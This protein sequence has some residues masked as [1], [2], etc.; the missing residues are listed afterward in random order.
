MA[1]HVE[2]ERKF[3]LAEGQELP[4]LAGVAGLGPAAEFDLV[5]TY[6]DSPDFRLAGARQVIRRRT[7]GTDDGWHLKQPGAGPDQR[8]E[9][10]APVEYRRPPQQFRELVAGNLNGAPLVPVAVLRTHR[11]ERQ[12]IGPDGTVLALV[13]TDLVDASAGGHRQRWREAEVE[14]VHGDA[15]FLDLVTGALAAAGVQLSDSPSKAGRALSPA[16]ADAAVADPSAGAAVL[17][18]VGVQIGVLQAQ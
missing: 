16:I 7:G 9:L 3:A 4:D 6:Y 15:A 11:A 13:C 8:G 10:Q 14:L 1:G 2:H 5:A 12:L 18:H 17:A